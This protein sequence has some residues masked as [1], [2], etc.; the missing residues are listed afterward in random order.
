MIPG[1]AQ[2]LPCVVT[3]AGVQ[4]L[5]GTASESVAGV[6]PVILIAHPLLMGCTCRI[7]SE[8]FCAVAHGKD[9]D[10]SKFSHKFFSNF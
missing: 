10:N 2:E 6:E 8:N 5:R 3:F 7:M 1:D 9:R 4:V